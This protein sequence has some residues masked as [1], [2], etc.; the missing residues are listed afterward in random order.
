MLLKVN[1]YKT[2]TYL[3]VTDRL[4]KLPPTELAV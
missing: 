1:F 4:L 3:N 2:Y